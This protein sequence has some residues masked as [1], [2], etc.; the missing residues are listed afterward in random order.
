MLLAAPAALVAAPVTHFLLDPW[1]FACFLTTPVGQVGSFF[2]PRIV[3][4]PGVAFAHFLSGAVVILFWPLLVRVLPKVE[5]TRY[6]IALSCLGL[7][8]ATRFVAS[9]V[10]PASMVASPSLTYLSFELGNDFLCGRAF[11]AEAVVLGAF[12]ASPRLFLRWL[13]PGALRRMSRSGAT[14]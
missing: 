10:V 11:L 6:A 14:P 2:G 1:S 5:A 7:M 13:A 4:L 9:L 3:D 8:V 12:V